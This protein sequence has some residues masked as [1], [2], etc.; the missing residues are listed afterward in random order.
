M[1]RLTRRL[2]VYLISHH[3]DKTAVSG[4]THFQ[5]DINLPRCSLPSLP[6]HSKQAE[7]AAGGDG[8]ETALQGAHEPLATGRRAL[9]APRVPGAPPLRR[10]TLDMDVCFQLVAACELQY[11]TSA[12]MV[13]LLYK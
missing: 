4:R 13:F 9:R 12:G 1:P 5:S 11:N 2:L 8:G 10:L 6:L 3:C 7:A